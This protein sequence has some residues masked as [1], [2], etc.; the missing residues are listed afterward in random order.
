M[1]TN[2]YHQKNLYH[3]RVRVTHDQRATEWLG[4]LTFI[5]QDNGSIFVDLSFDS[6]PIEHTSTE[7]L[8][9]HTVSEIS[10]DTIENTAQ[11]ANN[12]LSGI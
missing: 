12:W 8:W 9:D 10:V 4:L 2:A 11:P 3:V 1:V 5:P 7:Q 6:Q